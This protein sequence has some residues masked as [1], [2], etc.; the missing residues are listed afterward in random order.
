VD[1]QAII[2]GIID[3]GEQEIASIE[4]KANAQIKA[5]RD[6][7]E[8]EAN[9]QKNR[10]LK[11]AHVRMNRTQ[12]V[13]AQRTT[14]QALQ[15]HAN[16]RQQLI[17]KTLERSKTELMNIREKSNYPRIF[18]NLISDAVSAILPSLINDQN[19]IL[20][21]DERDKNLVKGMKIPGKDR[22]QLIFDLHC[23][24]GCEAEADDGMVKVRNTFESRF[25]RAL[26]QIQ[27]DLS[28][29]FEENVPS[30]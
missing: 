4:K 29:F 21:I 11:D 2:D 7:A 3:A 15:M 19:I 28:V 27:Q 13:V 16:A 18:E 22:V 17:L 24:G 12:A 20:H 25:E 8:A 14:M 26:P 10:I 9:K 5:I 6:N 23:S 1:I 30:G